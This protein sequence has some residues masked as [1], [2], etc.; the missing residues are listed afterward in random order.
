MHQLPRRHENMHMHA[1]DDDDAVTLTPSALQLFVKDAG[2]STIV[3]ME[4]VLTKEMNHRAQTSTQVRSAFTFSSQCCVHLLR[5]PA[6]YAN[7][8]GCAH[9]RFSCLVA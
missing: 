5:I 6:V 9:V 8:G 2:A 1:R 7:G 4:Q 3:E